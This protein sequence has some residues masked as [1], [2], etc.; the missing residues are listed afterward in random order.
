M[1]SLVG[2]DRGILTVD[3]S[4]GMRF[5]L[6]DQLRALGALA[7][8]WSH[9]VG[10][11][12]DAN[13]RSWTGLDLGQAIL[14]DPL[15]LRTNLGSF[16]V[17]LFF[18]VSGFV[19]THAAYRETGRQF[20]VRRLLRIYPPLF[21]AVL[22]T[23]LVSVVFL[24]PTAAGGPDHWLLQ[25]TLANWAI[26]PLVIAIPVTWT[27]FIEVAFYLIV[28]ASKPL[29]TRFTAGVPIAVLA[30]SAFCAV[31]MN[32]LGPSF[33]EA[34]HSL[35]LLPVLAIGQL[36]Y[37][38]LTRRLPLLAGAGLAVASWLLLLYGLRQSRPEQIG[39]DMPWG[40]S[41]AF[42][43]LLFLLAVT[44][45]GRF[46]G[47]R[48]LTVVAKRTY[49]V[50]LLHWPIGMTALTVTVIG[51]HLPYTVGLVIA[52]VLVAGFTELSY[53]FVERPWIALSRRIGRR[54]AD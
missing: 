17:A 19:I 29:L 40:A 22:V 15:G 47:S 36:T 20:I 1:T 49:S 52:L 12:L 45:E 27:L 5:V 42:A 53:R 6:V 13:D 10:A 32:S 16:G 46:S 26:S 54:P 11:W 4:P 48:V 14:T 43:G 3:A 2:A 44:L 8:L 50:Y 28:W 31:A 23:W 18:F 24:T 25:A 37:L 51:L 35:I 34:A 33:F 38:V 7:V 9:L 39:E 21:F 41:I 30:V